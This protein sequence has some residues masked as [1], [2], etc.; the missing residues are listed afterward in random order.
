LTK[1]RAYREQAQSII[2]AFRKPAHAHARLSRREREV[3]LLVAQGQSNKA[4]AVQLNLKP[5]TV[6]NYV[7]SI[8]AQLSIRARW[9]LTP[10]LIDGRRAGE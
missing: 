2:A 8:F 5:R 1:K 4:I 7:A 10:D 9:Q 3:A 6:E